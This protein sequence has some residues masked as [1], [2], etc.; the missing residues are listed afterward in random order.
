MKPHPQKKGTKFRFRLSSAVT[1]VFPAAA[2]LCNAPR[3]RRSNTRLI[4]S[5]QTGNW[6]QTNPCKQMARRTMS[7]LPQWSSRVFSVELDGAPL[8]FSVQE[9]HRG[10]EVPRVFRK[11]QNGGRCYS[12]LV[13]SND[14]I[15]RA[16]FYGELREKL[17]RDLP[18]E[19]DVSPM[20][21]FLPNVTDSLFKGYFLKDNSEGSSLSERVLRDLIQHDPVLVCSY[22]RGEDGQ[23]WT[24]HLWPDAD[25]QRMD[26]SQQYYV[27]PSETPSIHPSTLNIINSDVFYSFEEAYEVLKKVFTISFCYV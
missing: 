25:S 4:E 1:F 24:Q 9:K 13:C 6:I 19:C 14:R 3:I 16:K 27:V 15:R 18:P 23:L 20:S 17:Q 22:S 10:E 26:M 7:L 2:S 21:S 5:N 8:Y 11:V 12:L